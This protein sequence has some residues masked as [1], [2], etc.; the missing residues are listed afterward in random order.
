M[1]LEHH[2]SIVLDYRIMYSRTPK[3]SRNRSADEFST[4]TSK[5]STLAKFV[6]LA[7]MRVDVGV[8]SLSAR[9][10]KV[11]HGMRREGDART[12]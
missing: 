6:R 3:S 11:P 8:H 12:V 10:F 4:S 2:I 5:S 1:Y 9:S 7:L